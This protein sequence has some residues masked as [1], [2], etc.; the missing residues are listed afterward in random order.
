[1]TL[2]IFYGLCGITLFVIG[3]Y[4][5]IMQPH[6]LQKIIA[7]NIMGSGCFLYLIALARTADGV[8]DSVPHAMVITGIVVAVSTTA[9]ALVLMNKLMEDDKQQNHTELDD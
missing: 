8:T 4:G 6:V 2:M 9:V 3:L 5:L 1:M 7:V